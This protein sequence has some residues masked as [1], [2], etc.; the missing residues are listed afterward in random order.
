MSVRLRIGRFARLLVGV[1]AGQAG[2]QAITA[3]TGLLMVHWLSITQYAEYTFAFGF[4]STVLQL[5]DLGW[6]DA[7]FAVIGE[8][9]AD[10]EVVSQVLAAARSLR[11][12]F[13]AVLTPLSAIAFV[14]LVGRHSWA[15]DAC[16]VMFASV[17]LTLVAR[18]YGDCYIVPLLIAKRFRSLYAMNMAAALSR[19]ACSGLLKVTNALTGPTAALLSSISIALNSLGWWYEARSAVRVPRRAEPK[20]RAAILRI[21]LPTLPAQIFFGLQGQITI[22]LVTV[23]GNDAKLASLG[24]LT[25]LAVGFGIITTAVCY[26]FV[27]RVASARHERVLNEV[28]AG[29][30]TVGGLGAILTAGAFSFPHAYLFVLGHRYAGLTSACSWCMCAGAV[31]AVAVCLNAMTIARGYVWWWTSAAQVAAILISEIAGAWIFR[32]SSLVQL[33]YWSLGWEVPWL[34]TQVAIFTYGRRRDV[35]ARRP[36]DTSAPVAR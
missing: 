7:I 27:P 10:R 5:T 8:R 29:M 30:A 28:A 31:F 11:W 34:A 21:A 36:P 32:L 20:Y 14:A 35:A 13:V 9:S 1:A 4:G 2:A 24:A 6:S 16:L 23:T 15:A 22:F 25:R 33:Q 3:A 18:T 12:L 26:V 19:V 17:V